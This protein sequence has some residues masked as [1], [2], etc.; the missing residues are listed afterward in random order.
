MKANLGLNTA[1]SSFKKDHGPPYKHFSQ[2]FDPLE[3]NEYLQAKGVD[4]EALRHAH[5]KVQAA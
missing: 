1:Y 2:S 3:N 5:S 4:V